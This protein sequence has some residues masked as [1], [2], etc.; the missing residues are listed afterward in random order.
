M[1][2][3]HRRW[4]SSVTPRL[5]QLRDHRDGA[6]GRPRGSPS[7]AGWSCPPRCPRGLQPRR[8]EA[9][10]RGCER[11]QRSSNS[12]YGS[13][14]GPKTNPAI[15]LCYGGVSGWGAGIRRLAYVSAVIG[16]YRAICFRSVTCETI[17]RKPNRHHHAISSPLWAG[18]G[19]GIQRPHCSSS[20]VLAPGRKA[21]GSAGF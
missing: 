6:P 16:L 13:Q 4:T 18:R 5:A 17:K 7:D 9:V 11:A 8:P 1:T 20:P 15:T 19:T 3:N 12:I 2:F 14:V 10:G 21:G